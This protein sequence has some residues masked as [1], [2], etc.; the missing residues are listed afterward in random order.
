MVFYRIKPYSG[1]KTLKMYFLNSIMMIIVNWISKK[2]GPV[3]TI[4]H[5]KKEVKQT[6]N[7]FL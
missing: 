1:E 2:C 3:Q 6:V 5:L 7:V 4:D